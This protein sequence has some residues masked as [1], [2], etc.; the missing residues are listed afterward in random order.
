[1][2]R[3]AIAASRKDWVTFDDEL[4]F[5]S[6]Y[7]AL[8]R[9]RHGERLRFRQGRLSDAAKRVECPP[10]ILQP[11]VENAI[12]H[13][14]ESLSGPV[15][16]EMSF[17]ERSDDIELTIRNPAAEQSSH[18]GHGIGIENLRGRLAMLYQ[19]RARLEAGRDGRNFVVQ[20]T[21]PRN[22]PD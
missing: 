14:L 15:D 9:L 21:V 1:L 16:I 20:L 5:V 7:V 10:L 4:D 8:Q 18:V 19:G 13:G 6:G 11:L 3:Y 12:R 22:A 17:N 2:L